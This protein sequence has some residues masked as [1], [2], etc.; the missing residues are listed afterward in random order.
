MAY[1]RHEGK[2]GGYAQIKKQ[3]TNDEQLSNFKTSIEN[4]AAVCSKEQRENKFTMLYS[5]FLRDARKGPD[6]FPW[7]EW[8]DVDLKRYGLS[9]ADVAFIDGNRG[10][11]QM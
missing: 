2:S 4:Y 10:K 1:P 8:I 3:I 5:T 11:D 7:L 6:V 9:R